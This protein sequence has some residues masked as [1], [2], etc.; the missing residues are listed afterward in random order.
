MQ[1][2][3][4]VHYHNP[5]ERDAESMINLWYQGNSHSTIFLS[6]TVVTELT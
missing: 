2:L 3:K 1:N 6:Q 5:F 4:D